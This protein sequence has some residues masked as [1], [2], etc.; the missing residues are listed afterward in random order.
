[1]ISGGGVSGGGGGVSVIAPVL[2][3]GAT[4][5]MKLRV[6]G[7]CAGVVPRVGG[8][9]SALNNCSQSNLSRDAFA[10]IAASAGRPYRAVQEPCSVSAA[11]GSR[12]VAGARVRKTEQRLFDKRRTHHLKP[13]REPQDEF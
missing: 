1:M 13:L 9:E 4:G 5:L 6:S 8:A 3:C 7:H 12:F 10:A 2:S 11:T